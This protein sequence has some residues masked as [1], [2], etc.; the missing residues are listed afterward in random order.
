M[1]WG[2]KIVLAFIAFMVFLGVLVYRS[3]HNKVHLV[4]RDYYEKELV[5]QQEIDKII[6]EKSL[7]ESVNIQI[8]AN[9]DQLKVSF[10]VGQKVRTGNLELYRPSDASMDTSWQLELDD[11][12]KFTLFTGDLAPGLWKVKLEWADDSRS[13]LKE[14]N[15]FLP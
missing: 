11:E 13:Y 7:E 12:N 14:Q 2:H 3:V 8:D 5:Y 1:N 10:P 15:L 4:S 9:A 6:N